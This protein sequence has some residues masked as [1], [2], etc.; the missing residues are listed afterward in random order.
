MFVFDVTGVAGARAEIR[1]QALTVDTDPNTG[2]TVE[3]TSGLA[4]LTQV[5]IAPV[6]DP[7]TLAAWAPYCQARDRVLALA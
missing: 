2:A 5:V 1:V 4:T 6:A 7:V 3:A